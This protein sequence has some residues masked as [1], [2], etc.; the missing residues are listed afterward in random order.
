MNRIFFIILS[1]GVLFFS[2]N[3]ERKK[4]N[5]I[6]GN[7]F[8]SIPDEKIE[9]SVLDNYRFV[10][11]PRNDDYETA[12]ININ[13]LSSEDVYFI[14]TTTGSPNSLSAPSNNIKNRGISS[15]IANINTKKNKEHISKFNE[16]PFAYI[17]LK[18]IDKTYKNRLDNS[19]VLKRDSVIGDTKTF[20]DDQDGEIE[21][22][23]RFVDNIHGKTLNIWVENRYWFSSKD[24]SHVKNSINQNMIEKLAD[25]FL[26]SRK[27]DI[28]H[29]V[30]NIFGEEWGSHS[31][32]EMIPASEAGNINILLC[33]I[34]DDE[35]NFSGLSKGKVLGY[36][37]S[38]DN[39]TVV[40]QPNPRSNRMLMFY[41]DAPTFS[42]KEDNALWD[43][44]GFWSNEIISTLA[45]EFQHM[46]HFYQKAVKTGTG[47][48]SD[49]WLDEM[50]SMVTEDLLADK[51][52][53]NGPRGV[54]S[55]NPSSKPNNENGK[56]TVFNRYNGEDLTSWLG[57]DDVIISYANSYAF[58]A[59]IARNFGGAELFNRIVSVNTNRN[60]EAVVKSINDLNGTSETFFSLLQKWSVAVMLSDL[61]DN[62]IGYKY[63]NGDKWFESNFN[64]YIYKL[65]SINLY[66]YKFSDSLTGPY[67]VDYTNRANIYFDTNDA[68]VDVERTNNNSN[69]YIKG[70][71]KI[72]G[73]FYKKLY[74]IPN[75]Y[76]TIV[77]K[78]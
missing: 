38:K 61:T 44:N 36:F 5:L 56:L 73:P 6:E 60:Y 9:M 23:C 2:C 17:N 18:D 78:K 72:N 32:S 1:I 27:E 46:I 75:Q 41:I 26:N 54:E 51:L 28:Y 21:A 65:G 40:P 55:D 39:F 25:K 66:N 3:I 19:N 14:I 7:F 4:D 35:D 48:S 20:Y 74:L 50:C 71:E 67:F 33:D 53:T 57:D 62:E 29:W 52:N 59:Y 47:K 16:N 22:T 76:V 70:G 8:Y 30:T 64:N 43:I 42:Y 34:D 13:D 12:H 68:S 63:N 31:F 11:L 24:P 45:H 77:F 58:G 49:T 15:N 69:Y 37:Y 10:T